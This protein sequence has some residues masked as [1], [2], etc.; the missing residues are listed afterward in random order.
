MPTPAARPLTSPAAA[1]SDFAPA[2]VSPWQIGLAGARANLVPGICLQI[3]ALGL[4]AAYY[5]HQPT[6]AALERLAAFRVE[7]G[8]PFDFV[9]TGLFGAAVPF[10]VLKLSRATRS[11]FN[12]PQMA[13]ITA[14]WAYKGVEV[15]CFYKLQAH[16]FG[17]G[18]D[19]TTI[20][21]KTFMDEFVYC[22]IFAVPTTW[23]IYAW[24]ESH[25]NNAYVLGE[26]RRPRF[27]A[28]CVL[29]VLI[30]NWGVW[31]PAVAII[32]ILPTALQLPLQNIVLCFFTLL[33]AFI[34]RRPAADA[35]S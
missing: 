25:F 27:Y 10:L 24:A 26:F 21:L 33:L 12:F 3:F 31:T 7:V 2:A 22:P 16:L 8:V 4:L 19:A 6:R 1:S 11:R 23:L 35:E 30:A 32:Y 18:H 28:R 20:L 5:L 17:T 9:S 15:S 29:P 13:A 34:T 14:Y